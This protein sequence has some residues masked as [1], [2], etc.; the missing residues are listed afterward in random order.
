MFELHVTRRSGGSWVAELSQLILSIPV[1]CAGAL[2]RGFELRS[3]D[4]VLRLRV[5]T[6]AWWPA[7]V[8]M[9]DLNFPSFLRR[10]S[11]WGWNTFWVSFTSVILSFTFFLS[12]LCLH[13]YLRTDLSLQF[14]PIFILLLSGFIWFSVFFF[15]FLSIPPYQP[16]SLILSFL[17]SL[18]LSV[19]IP[20]VFYALFSI[21]ICTSVLTSFINSLI[22]SSCLSI[23]LYS[24]R[25]LCCV[26]VLYL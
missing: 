9:T 7:E 16:F 12:V 26:F 2:A 11:G 19:F 24:F 17:L 23:S 20:V 14:S 5:W 25:L 21:C 18:L 1:V 10:D 6:G 15:L 22:L 13:L 8:L 3:C 4:S